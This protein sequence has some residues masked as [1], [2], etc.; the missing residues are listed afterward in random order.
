[1]TLTTTQRTFITSIKEKICLAQY[2]ALKE[3]NT[4]FY[5]EY[6]K[7]EFLQPLVTEI[8]WTKHITI[9]TIHDTGGNLV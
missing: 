7:V 6:Q 3:V 5:N 2:E 4:Q 9:A 8:I 1:M